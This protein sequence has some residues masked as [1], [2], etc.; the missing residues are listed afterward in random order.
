MNP[1][2]IIIA[3]PGCSRIS[4]V[5]SPG[6]VLQTKVKLHTISVSVSDQ[7]NTVLA[8]DCLILDQMGPD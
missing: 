7:Q 8:N 1:G 5:I 6:I 2:L 4:S 3:N